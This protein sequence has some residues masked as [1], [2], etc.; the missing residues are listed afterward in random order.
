MIDRSAFPLRT[1]LNVT[2]PT[3]AVGRHLPRRGRFAR[4]GSPHRSP[5]MVAIYTI[6]VF[7][8]VICALNFFEF[9][10]LD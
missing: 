3:Q 9:G 1:I 4:A 7:I 8:G 5:A 2:R 6:L 10:R